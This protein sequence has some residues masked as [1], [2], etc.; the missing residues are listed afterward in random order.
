M[1]SS[2]RRHAELVLDRRQGSRG[3]LDVVFRMI[4]LNLNSGKTQQ[5]S[6]LMTLTIERYGS[7]RSY[8][9]TDPLGRTNYKFT[10]EMTS[11]AVLLWS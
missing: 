5:H 9:E 11:T 3:L 4:P 7:F 8:N 2:D 6:R 1:C 10:A